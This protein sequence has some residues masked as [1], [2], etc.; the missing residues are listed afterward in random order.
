MMLPVRWPVQGKL[1]GIAFLLHPQRTE[2]SGAPCQ[3]RR[4]HYSMYVWNG[5]WVHGLVGMVGAGWGWT[6]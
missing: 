2:L 1:N 5:N 3:Q 4:G 6:R